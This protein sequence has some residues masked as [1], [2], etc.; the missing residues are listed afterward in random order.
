MSQAKPEKVKKTPEELAAEEQEILERGNVEEMADFYDR[1]DTSELPWEEDASDQGM[2]MGV[3]D[4]E[5]VSIRLPREDLEQIRR[6][7]RAAGVGYTTMIR[8]IVHAHLENPLT[9]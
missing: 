4:M 2:I 6:R 5:Q 9:Y 1:T 7:A 8:M 3:E